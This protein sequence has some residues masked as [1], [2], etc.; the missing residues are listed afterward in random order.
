VGDAGRRVQTLW[1]A[2]VTEDYRGE[3]SAPGKDGIPLY[4]LTQNMPPDVHITSWGDW[5]EVEERQG[6]KFD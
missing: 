6:N 5:L 1:G 4:D 2:D 3:H